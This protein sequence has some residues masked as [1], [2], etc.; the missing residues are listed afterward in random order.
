MENFCTISECVPCMA[1]SAPQLVYV[2]AL[3]FARIN[4]VV[5]HRGLDVCVYVF[6]RAC[7]SES[8]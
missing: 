8:S 1:P 5:G 2:C 6:V 4:P 3:V 7:G